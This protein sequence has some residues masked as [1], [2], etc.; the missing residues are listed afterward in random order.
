MKPLRDALTH[1]GIS[2]TW[3]ITAA[4]GVLAVAFAAVCIS[5]AYAEPPDAHPN[6]SA[7]DAVILQRGRYLVR[8]T[9]CNDCHT[10]RYAETG[11]A[12][13]QAQWLTGSAIGFRGPWGTSY[14]GNL[15]RT[16]QSVSEWQWLV[17]ARTH[18][19][20]PLPR[21]SLAPMNDD[22]LLAVCRLA[23][24]L[25]LRRRPAPSAL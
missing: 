19:L 1:L 22:D 6:S 11:G 3:P 21:F 4:A 12:V 7:A 5:H 13:P 20:Q 8:I 2:M 10:P 16:V 14:P 15:R 24:S 17:F 25:G 23:R 18:R 9:G